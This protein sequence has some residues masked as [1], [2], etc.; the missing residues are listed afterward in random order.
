MAPP[1]KWRP[2][3]TAARSQAASWK[4][5]PRAPGHSS[6][7]DGYHLNPVALEN[8][9]LPL[10]LQLA[11]ALSETRARWWP[12]ARSH[13]RGFRLLPLQ[14]SE[15]GRERLRRTIF[16]RE[17]APTRAETSSGA[18]RRAPPSLLGLRLHG[19]QQLPRAP[20]PLARTR[21]ALQNGSP[22]R[23]WKGWRLR[24]GDKV[25]LLRAGAGA[26]FKLKTRRRRPVWSL[27][28]RGGGP[29]SY[30]G[31]TVGNQRSL[32]AKT[33]KRACNPLL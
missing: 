13:N 6:R 32:S 12:G 19:P 30:E 23:L 24:E 28:A 25:L 8:T 22:G 15:G 10:V 29:R 3:S 18:C 27:A 11:K 33:P 21:S 17:T 2:S 26:W 20:L 16:V 31:E 5:G 4:F 9:F 7:G 14:R 1:R